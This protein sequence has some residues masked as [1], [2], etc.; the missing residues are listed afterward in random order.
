MTNKMLFTV[1]GKIKTSFSCYN[2]KKTRRWMV[3]IYKKQEDGWME[4]IKNK[5]I[6]GWDIW[7]TRRW[8]ASI[9][10]KKRRLMDRIY[11]K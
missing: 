8:M 7:K 2:I 11:R 10:R 4:Y 9:F 5:K 6:D 3:G 1:A